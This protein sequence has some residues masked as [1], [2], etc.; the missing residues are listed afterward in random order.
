MLVNK[1]EED[2]VLHI[3]Q[4]SSRLWRRIAVIA[5]GTFVATA[6]A[7]A[8]RP[9]FQSDETLLLTLE[10]EFSALARDR[11]QST[12]PYRPAVLSYLASD[13]EKRSLS[14]QVKTRGDFRLQRENCSFLALMLN[15]R[16]SDA[17]GTPFASQQD[18]PLVTHCRN[19]NRY[20]QYVLR[21]Y[22]AYR[23]FNLM[24]DKSLRARLARIT[25]LDT[26]GD[27]LTTRYAFFV[28][29]FDSMAQRLDAEIV[30][31]DAFD[32]KSAKG[33]DLGMLYIFQFLI[34]NTDFS[35]MGG[36]NILLLQMSD[37]PI[38][39]V[40]YDLDFAGAVDAPY[41]TPDARLRL[42]SVRV[43]RYRGFCEP[44]DI[45]QQVLDYYLERETPLYA[46][47]REQEGL[48]DRSRRKSVH[49]LD[50]FFAMLDQPNKIQKSIRYG[51]W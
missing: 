27:S 42:P 45:L 10:S 2:A 18:V 50:S 48:S 30:H 16:S 23:S 21:E 8:G 9:L 20:E 17:T 13:G 36:H 35:V 22:L 28:E 44:A 5:L 24:T 15:F 39:P 7:D 25:Y 47:Y 40:P 3:G 1:D 43:R 14:L 49:Y 37:G 12:S 41:A 29:H 34:G 31:E 11:K 26:D 51:C 19:Q 6:A 33:F 38:V 46:L 4:H 32:I